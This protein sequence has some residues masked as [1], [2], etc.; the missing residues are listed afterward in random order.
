MPWMGLIPLAP[1]GLVPEITQ[2]IY[3]KGIFAI[4]EACIL[5]IGLYSTTKHEGMGGASK[6]PTHARTQLSWHAVNKFTHA[7]VYVCVRE[8]EARALSKQVQVRN[9]LKRKGNNVAIK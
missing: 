8:P 5:M 9:S 7:V 4:V 2:Q 1:K 3:T 6:C